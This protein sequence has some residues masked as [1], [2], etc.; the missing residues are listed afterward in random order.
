MKLTIRLLALILSLLVLIGVTAACGNKPKTSSAPSPKTSSTEST[1]ESSGGDVTGESSETGDTTDPSAEGPTADE[2]TSPSGSNSQGKNPATKPPAK[3]TASTAK[4]TTPSVKRNLKGMTFT[5]ADMWG[6]LCPPD[7]AGKSEYY[8]AVLERFEQVKKDTGCKVVI[9]KTGPY[10]EFQ[11]NFNAACLSNS[12][13]AD[14]IDSQ[15]WQ[16]RAWMR[17]GYLAPLDQI[18]TIDL[19]KEKYLDSKTN[20]SYYDGHYYGTDFTSWYGRYINFNSGAMLVNLDLMEANNI[21]IYKII[22]SGQ[23]TRTKFRELAKKFTYSKGG[24]KIDRWGV[25][26][27]SWNNMLWATGER[28]TKWNGKK[29]VFGMNN[30]N[31]MGAMQYLLDM[32]Y[33]DQSVSWDWSLSST[34]YGAT[35]LWAKQ[36]VAFYP[37][38]MEWMTYGDEEEAWFLDVD[39]DYGLIPYPNFSSDKAAVN[40]K[41]QFYGEI[42]LY[43]IPKTAAK[44][45]HTLEDVGYFFELLTEPLAGTDNNSWKTYIRDEIFQ[46]N[47]KSFNM[48]YKMLTNA[49]FDHAVD[50]G[51][52]QLIPWQTTMNKMYQKHEMTPAEA[53]Q[54][55]AEA[56]QMY[57]D[58]HVN[59]DAKLLKS[60]K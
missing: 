9:K 41:G 21:D 8:D 32:M 31:A 22:E 10:S 50:M 37:I 40:Y 14:I 27:I 19:K 34:Y 44:G 12:F 54:T 2:T 29:Y 17:Q 53:I 18:K 26:S 3:T 30:S 55:E 36:K 38:D 43:S 25:C 57:L 49:E 24:K 46:G 16:T 28:T 60:H 59:N 15:I 56:F 13:Y 11:T 6:Q 52:L 23:W 5:I 48:Y 45:G 7:K 39:F 47:D 4:P 20:L 33:T 35:D 1:V 42:R 51:A 58:G